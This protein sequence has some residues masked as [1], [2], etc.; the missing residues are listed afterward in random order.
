MSIN[1]LQYKD[2]LRIENI[3]SKSYVF[4]PIR[5]KY[6]ILLPEELTRQLL[7]QYLISEKN[8][9]P[10]LIQVEKQLLVNGIKRRYDIVAFDRSFNPYLLIECKSHKIKIHQQTFD[11]ISRYNL[12]LKSPFLLISNGTTHISYAINYAE[13]KIKIL[14]EIPAFL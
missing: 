2:Q 7:I 6:V 8:Y 5:K 1:L 11:Q 3:G 13:K 14:D 4:D 9:R 12:N 10:A